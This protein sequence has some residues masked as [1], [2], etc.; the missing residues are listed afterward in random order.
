MIVANKTTGPLIDDF[1]DLI[2]DY[3][4]KSNRNISIRA[5]NWLM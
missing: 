2:L 1:H 5:R 4:R 3:A